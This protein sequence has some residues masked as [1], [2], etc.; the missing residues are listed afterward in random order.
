MAPVRKP[1]LI[2]LLLCATT[3]SLTLL[4]G[5]GGSFQ[6]APTPAPTPAP[7]SA[8]NLNLVFVASE[9]L[10]Y[11]ATG[12]V[13]LKTA[14]LT[15]K[16]LE[17]SLM[18][19]TFLQKNVLGSNNVSAIY[20]LAPMTHPQTANNYPDMVG[21]EAMQQFAMLNQITLSYG[22]DAPVTR[23]S[24]P[25]NVAYSSAKLPD[26]VAQPLVTCPPSGSGASYSCQGLDFRDLD[27]DNEALVN[28]IVT[29]N[30]P[31]VYAFSAPWE[32]ISALMANI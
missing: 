9:D 3:L 15:S 11:H 22:S 21:L 16:G 20:T 7:L 2:S 14:N 18:M 1:A 29:A 6:P 28:D 19:A 13:N 4:A 30:V 23:N 27:G 5:C 17:R 26:G 12:D 10:S 31:G 25:L 24:Y 8:D 32:T